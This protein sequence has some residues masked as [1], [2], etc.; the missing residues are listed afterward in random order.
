MRKKHKDYAIRRNM[1]NKISNKTT[2]QTNSLMTELCLTVK[3]TD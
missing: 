2:Y 3:I 1:L